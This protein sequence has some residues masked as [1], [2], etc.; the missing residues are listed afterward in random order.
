MK[1]M[2]RKIISA[3]LICTLISVQAYAYTNDEWMH[4][5]NYEGRQNWQIDRGEFCEYLVKLYDYVTW[6]KPE[7]IEN[8]FW[9]LEEAQHPYALGAYSLGL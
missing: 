3:A 5:E 8:P 6:G 1:R 4:V 7:L 9:D 2:I